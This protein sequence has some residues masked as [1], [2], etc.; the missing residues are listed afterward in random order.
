MSR[1][2]FGEANGVYFGDG[3]GHFDEGVL[4]GR[5]DG[6]T[7]AV[8]TTDLDRDGHPD[9]VVGNVGMQ[10]AAYFNDG[11]GRSF[12]EVRFGGAE[13]ITYGVAVGD[14]NGDGFPDIGVANSEGLNGVHLNR[15]AL[16]T[17]SD[18]TVPPEVLARYVGTYELPN[19]FRFGITLAGNQL[20]ARL[21]GGRELPLFAASE[22]RFLL[23]SG[24]P[25]FEFVGDREGVVTHFILHQAR[26]PRTSRT[27]T[28]LSEVLLAEVDH[29]SG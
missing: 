19:G 11:T 21:P 18:I 22:A 12:D 27:H 24:V 3:N 29:M 10:N 8:I 16:M 14:I 9:I 23:G 5:P 26:P 17:A 28:E 25:E 1:Q 6:Q 7:Y 15:P 2:I 4:F 20:M 13:D